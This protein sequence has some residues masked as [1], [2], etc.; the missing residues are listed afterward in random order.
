MF[1]GLKGIPMEFTGQGT[2]RLA[3]TE[4]R[5]ILEQ[6]LPAQIQFGSSQETVL[7][8]AGQASESSK[9]LILGNFI[10]NLAM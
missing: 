1:V 3:S 4:N 7:A 10:F 2:R 9:V 8:A 6:L 5:L